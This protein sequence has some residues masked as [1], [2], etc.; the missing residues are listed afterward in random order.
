MIRFLSFVK[1]P[2]S[3][4]SIMEIPINVSDV[5]FVKEESSE[6]KTGTSKS[7]GLGPYRH[8]DWIFVRCVSID[9]EYLCVS[10][11]DTSEIPS[12]FSEF[13]RNLKFNWQKLKFTAV[14]DG[15]FSRNVATP[16]SL[17]KST[18]RRVRR[19]RFLNFDIFERTALGDIKLYF[20]FSAL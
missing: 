16:S 5:R 17:P 7:I 18:L 3:G 4:N 13:G 9:T 15:K 19:T 1:F 12:F 14:N 2:S 11:G 20:P 6:Q 10:S 8:S